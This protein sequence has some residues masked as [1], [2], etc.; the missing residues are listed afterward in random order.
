MSNTLDNFVFSYRF[1]K[2]KTLKESMQFYGLVV[3]YHVM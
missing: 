3:L 1:I 2:E